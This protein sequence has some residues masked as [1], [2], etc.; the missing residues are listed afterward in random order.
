MTCL[1]PPLGHRATCC[2]RASGLLADRP[3]KSQEGERNPRRM[4][5]REGA[6]QMRRMVVRAR[7]GRTRPRGVLTSSYNTVRYSTNPCG[8]VVYSTK[9]WYR[10]VPARYL[11]NK[12]YNSTYGVAQ[13]LQLQ[14][15]K[16][17]TR[18]SF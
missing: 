8:I 15:T 4:L 3:H 5:P 1:V 13:E 10:T 17:K 9:V 16:A 18:K 7:E 11:Y 6:P 2:S 14:V 12:T